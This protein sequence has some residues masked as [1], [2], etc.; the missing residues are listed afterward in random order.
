MLVFWCLDFHIDS[1]IPMSRIL[2]DCN[3]LDLPIKSQ[4]FRHIDRFVQLLQLDPA[5]VQLDPSTIHPERL[6]G[7]PLGLEVR[8]PLLSVTVLAAT[9]E[10]LEG[11][12]QVPESSVHG[13]LARLIRPRKLFTTDSIELLLELVSRELLAGFVLALP[14]G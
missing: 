9:K 14:F 3:R 5:S 6:S 1:G 10:I 4:F 7:L 12:V 8:I 11:A 13:T 2:R